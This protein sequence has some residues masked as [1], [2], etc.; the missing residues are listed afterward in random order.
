MKW[1]RYFIAGAVAIATMATGVAQYLKAVPDAPVKTAATA[2]SPIPHELAVGERQPAYDAGQPY[3]SIMNSELTDTYTGRGWRGS[4]RSMAPTMGYPS[5]TFPA[6][7][8]DSPLW[9]SAFGIT[10]YLPVSAKAPGQLSSFAEGSF[11]GTNNVYRNPPQDNIDKPSG[12]WSDQGGMGSPGFAGPTTGPGG[13][14]EPF[15]T[16]ARFYNNVGVETKRQSYSFSYGY[17]HTNDFV[18]LRNVMYVTG[19]VDVG[20]D[21]SFEEMGTT[22]RNFFMIYNYDFDIP[23]TN[24][25]NAAGGNVTGATGGDDKQPPGMFVRV[26][27]KV[28]PEGLINSGRFN[29]PPYGPRFYSGL[30]TM[31][32]EDN[33]GVAGVDSY[34]WN[35]TV[36]NFN[37][38]HTGEAS[39]MV[40]EGDGTGPIGDLDAVAALDI[41]EAPSVGLF[42]IH[43]WWK[44]DLRGVFGWYQGSATKYLKDYK[45]NVGGNSDP[46]PDLFISG[47]TLDKDT[48]ISTWT[49]KTQTGQ[50]AEGLG[51]LWGD[52]RNLTQANNPGLAADI[53]LAKGKY[54]TVTLFDLDGVFAGIVPDPYNGSDTKEES[55]ESGCI[56]NAL[57]WGPYTKAPGE[58]MTT[59]HVDI[60]GAGKD[61]A[62]DVYQRALDVWMQRKYNPAND[63]YYW[64]GSNDRTIPMYNSDG[65]VVRDADGK[66]MTETINFGRGANSGA[67]F[68]PPPAPTLS[69]FATNAGTVAL[70]WADN[71]ESAVDPGTGTVDF[72]GYRVYRASG[73]IDQFPTVIEA[74]RRG[75]NS[76]IIPP[77]M[78]LTRGATAITDVT[79]PTASSV[80]QGHPY[81]RFIHE[82]LTL[83]ADYNIGRVY[84]FVAADLVNKFASPNF[85]GPYVQIAEFG[86]GGSDQT[87]S[88]NPPAV[89]RYANPLDDDF[90]LPGFEE[91]TI[92][93]VPSSSQ[94]VESNNSRGATTAIAVTFPDRYPD[95]VGSGDS[96]I[97][98]IGGIAVDSRLVGQRGYIFEDKTTLTG[99]S[100]WY[101]VASVDNESAV[102][103]DFDNYVQDQS[104]S[105]RQIAR[106]IAGLESFYTMNANGTDGRWH[107]QFPYRGL[108]VGPQVPGQDVVPVPVPLNTVAGGRAEFLTR[109]T[110]A[111]NPFVFQ[112]DWDF[113]TKSQSVKFFN[114]PIPSRITIFDSSGLRVRQ[115]DT[116]TK[117]TITLGGSTSWNLRNDSNVP[118]SS[119]LY[120]CVIEAELDGQD[121][122]KTMKLYV[123]R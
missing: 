55:S 63:T 7:G 42:N 21:G 36:G 86:G 85:A 34:L 39:I 50:S 118:V 64:D 74:H 22:V 122:A 10:A 19:D 107:G 56:R 113:A 18:L 44:S 102:Q 81:A 82:G 67:L 26:M 35:T 73:Y 46:N 23:W 43:E 117:K 77:N 45:I 52:P 101:Y 57:G 30:V 108:T 100:Y 123:R 66:V 120:I 25:P 91:D 121:Y 47:S 87:N 4:G 72:A 76:T 114:I 116:G 61:G 37:P 99:F 84:D 17:G 90:R 115:F 1:R 32:D 65:S 71:A 98:S 95:N 51:L 97:T 14:R 112:A 89:V 94:I 105:Q 6:G 69:V 20:R 29:Q 111:P 103:L 58:N 41:F 2:G 70:A 38:L 24:N 15:I 33:I 109:A 9:A 31:F 40:L 11:V 54:D 79:D 60:I 49:A 75:Y 78:G 3:M 53:G 59:W 106:T 88:F 8:F 92:E 80:K 68:H 119:G 16:E 62:Y 48:D 28:V 5:F 12:F 93:T 96:A 110:V 27:P 104:S 83:G 13:Y